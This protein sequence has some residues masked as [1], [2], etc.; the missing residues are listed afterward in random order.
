MARTARVKTME[1]GVAYYHVTSR[2]N[3]RRFLFERGEMRTMLVDALRR[4]AEF[5]GV[6][7][8]AYVA[9]GNHFHAVVRVT[10]TDV[11]VPEGE[12][13]RRVGVLGGER[14]ARALA[15]RWAGLAAAGAGAAL[16][17]EADRLRARM[18]DVSEFVKAF[19]ELFDRR[20]KRER[21]HCGSIWSGRFK[22]TMVEDGRYLAV[23]KKYVF[24][25]PVRAGLVRRA[26]DYR[27]GWCA[28]DA[29]G[30]VP[31][32]AVPDGWCLGRRAQLVSGRVYGSEGFVRGWASAL[33]S[34]FRAKRVGPRRMV[35]LPAEAGSAVLG[36]RLAERDVA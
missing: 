31:A 22:S 14:A 28:D 10:R 9:M 30:D 2:A 6:E 23:C 17:G 5:S 11:P 24:Y 36:W 8:L 35:G 16:E 1:S 33:G 13:V 32:G 21:E 18:N 27:W 26:A 20:Y 12:L 19:K 7:L 4:A 34:R 25:N 15:R 29:E 3:G